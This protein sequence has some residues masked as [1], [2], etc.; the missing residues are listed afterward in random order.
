MGIGPEPAALLRSLKLPAGFTVCELGSQI[1]HQ[2]RRSINGKANPE[3]WWKPARE[4][5]ES[6]GCGRYE[7]IDANGK[8][9]LLHDLNQ[10]LDPWPGEFDLVTDFGTGEHIWDVAQV[11]RTMH[12]LTKPGGLIVFDKPTQGYE[13]HGFWGHNI[14]VLNDIARANHYAVLHLAP[15]LAN[16]GVCYRGTYRKVED[17]PFIPP[18]QGKYKG[19]LKVGSD[20][21]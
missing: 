18:S 13:F 21:V 10:P 8:A 3:W 2:G 14:T 7:S 19:K 20:A 1:F 11:W 17:A 15:V 12:D 9:T 6:M 4:L 16:R 5:Y